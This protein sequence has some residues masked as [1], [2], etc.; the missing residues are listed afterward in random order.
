[1]LNWLDR[2][3]DLQGLRRWALFTQDAQG[4]YEAHGWSVYP[5]PERMMTRDDPEIYA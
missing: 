3:A 4:L 1:M 5:H 2:H